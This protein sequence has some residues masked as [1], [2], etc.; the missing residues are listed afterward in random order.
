MKG[1][2][3]EKYG[4]EGRKIKKAHRPSKTRRDKEREA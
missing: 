1:E 4:E 2:E 3:Q